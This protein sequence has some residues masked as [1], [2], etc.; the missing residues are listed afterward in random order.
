MLR[1]R[2]LVQGN[3]GGDRGGRRE[4]TQRLLPA[5]LASVGYLTLVVAVS[6]AA[7]LAVGTSDAESHALQHGADP[8]PYSLPALQPYLFYNDTGSF[9]R[10]VPENATLWT[11]GI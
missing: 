10:I 5:V 8:A 7:P 9:S 1:W 2:T 4:M 3:C 11:A 6:A